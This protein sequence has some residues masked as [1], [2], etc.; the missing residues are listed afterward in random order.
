MDEET[1]ASKG[2][3]NQLMPETKSLNLRAEG[4]SA[5]VWATGF[6]YDFSWINYPVHDDAG[7]PVTD[8]GATIIP[9]LYFMGLNW[10]VKRKSG[11]II[12]VGNDARHVANHIVS[13]LKV[14]R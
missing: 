12:G 4:V 6:T 11:L 13:H 9:G 10:M 1:T 14:R 7:Y 2:L 3:S 5:V 8:R